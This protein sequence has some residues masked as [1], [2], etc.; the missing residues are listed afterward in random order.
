MALPRTPL[1]QRIFSAQAIALVA[2]CLVVG[3][4]ALDSYCKKVFGDFDYR[5]YYA[6]YL[7][8]FI[9]NGLVVNPVINVLTVREENLSSTRLP[10]WEIQLAP[11]KLAALNNNLPASGRTYQSGTIIINSSPFPARFRFRGDGFWHWGSKQ[12]SW[13]IKLKGD[14]RFEGK[15]EFN[16]INPREL[17]TLFWPITAHVAGSMGLATPRV[18]H[19]HARLNGRYL[20]LMLLVENLDHDFISHHD[21]PEGALYEDEALGSTP[22]YNS[23]E[24]IDN[25]N[26][27]RPNEK[28]DRQAGGDPEERYEKRLREL[29]Q[30]H[31]LKEDEEFF[32]ALER[33]V[34]VPRY[35]TWWAYAIVFIDTH[36]TYWH[37]NRFYLHAASGK[38]RHI[39]WD[40]M[41]DHN[42]GDKNTVDLSMNPLTDRL[43]Q[44][45]HHM[46]LRNKFLW[47]ALQGTAGSDELLRWVDGAAGLIREDLFC[48]PHKDMVFTVFPFFKSLRARKLTFDYTVAP[49]TN[50]MFEKELDILKTFLRDRAA[51]LNRT[52]SETSAEVFFSPPPSSGAR[53]PEPFTSAGMVSIAVGGHAGIEVKE[54]S[55]QFSSPRGSA[56]APFLFYGNGNPEQHIRQKGVPVRHGG[57]DETGTYTFSVDELLLPGRGKKPP[58]G[59]VPV[60]FV[61]TPAFEG[62]EAQA[63]VPVKITVKGVHPFTRQPITLEYPGTESTSAFHAA[64]PEGRLLPRAGPRREIVWDG[65]KRLEQDFRVG[66]DELLLIRPGTR[67]ELAQGA[68]LLS[69]GKVLAMGTA[70]LPI[71][72]TRTPDAS[73]WGALALQ[74]A[75]A[76]GSAFEHCIFEYGSE[77]EL[78]WVFY[79]GAL[80]IYNANATVSNC[81]FR[82]S[83]GDDALN[84]KHS[85]T[86]VTD[87]I[88]VDNKAD[89]YDVDFSDGLIARNLFERNGNDGIDCGT[90][91][92]AIRD[93]RVLNSGDKGI[94]IGERSRPLV[95]GN[96]ISHCNVGIAV[97][98]G[99]QPEIRNNR[100]LSNT[101]AVSAYQKKK[102]FGGAQAT[103]QSSTFESNTKVTETD[104]VSSVSLVD[105]EIDDA[106]RQND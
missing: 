106:V 69:Y 31:A 18:Q 54:I 40:M 99:S 14:Q 12:K 68:S 58:F 17:S 64:L 92:P 82:F 61:F 50:K 44:S 59:P 55:L 49:V 21:L 37:N 65:L 6:F 76:S 7:K 2:V 60:Q 75:K 25:W 80:S 102:A 35:L 20:G 94:S 84:T 45:P 19:V 16:L 79:S 105:C 27:R 57:T 73:T 8:D 89:G 33:L 32:N 13:K 47:E 104:E 1:R 63:P 24:R 23:W 101:V 11:R 4:Y 103:I 28:Q 30:C 22:F 97:K 36:Q 42:P 71:I 15:K 98:D 29:L 86:D 5:K 95:E 77:E 46:Y 39:P 85:H 83:Q 51:Y 34:D 66:K 56:D 90:A 70:V 87:S 53:L 9:W 74:G 78:D 43:S 88:F 3:I 93:N 62:S 26:I 67:I 96:F 52:L 81:L 100:F 38:F 72:F 10:V 91:Y 48:D 41:I